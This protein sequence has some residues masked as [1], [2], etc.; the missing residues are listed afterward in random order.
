[1]RP[2]GCNGTLCETWRAQQTGLC[3]PPLKKEGGEVR[4]REMEGGGG[5][6]AG[7]VEWKTLPLEQIESIVRVV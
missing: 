4:E 3:P 1:M 5:G 7:M 6:E 2:H